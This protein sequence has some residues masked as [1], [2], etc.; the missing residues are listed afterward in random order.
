MGLVEKNTTA[1]KKK[2]VA[3]MDLELLFSNNLSRSQ[4]DT[5]A[6]LVFV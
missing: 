3:D 4:K 6:W 5:K 1:K 2:S